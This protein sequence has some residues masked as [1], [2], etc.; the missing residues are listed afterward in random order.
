M[1]EK[2]KFNEKVKNSYEQNCDGLYIKTQQVK[3][4][5]EMYKKHEYD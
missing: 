5:H 4:R 2:Y 1:Q 3:S